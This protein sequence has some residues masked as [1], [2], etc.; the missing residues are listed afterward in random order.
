MENVPGIGGVGRWALDSIAIYVHAEYSPYI[1]CD[2]PRA[3]CDDTTRP[4]TVNIQ[5]GRRLA[6]AV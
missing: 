5:H 6:I 2:R 3:E 4:A 1:A